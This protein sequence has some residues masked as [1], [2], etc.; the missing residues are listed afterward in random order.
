MVVLIAMDYAMSIA[1][2]A[3]NTAA[4]TLLIACT[5]FNTMLT[6]HRD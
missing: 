1:D 2:A 5:A 3:S 6:M 4:G